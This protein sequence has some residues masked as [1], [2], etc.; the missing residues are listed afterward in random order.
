VIA[1]TAELLGEQ[2]YAR[3]RVGDVAQRA[4]VGL[5]AL[6]RRW[7]GKRELVLATLRSAVPDSDLLASD[8][9]AADVIDGLVAMSEGFDGPRGRLLTG[10]LSDLA[11]DV[12]LATAVRENI[13]AALR[14][15]HRERLRR[16]VG[17]RADLDLL[18][19][20]GPA[21]VLLHGVFLGH[22]VSR[23]ELRALLP[24]LTGGTASDIPE[25]RE[26]D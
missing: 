2:G 15:Q 9:P 3:L 6:Y 18:A 23:D 21:Y 10:L 7:P 16:L 25:S 20:L 22:T 12:D 26:R 4:G 24:I 13:L 14:T 8:D 19:D 17:E 1:A 5:G 11:D